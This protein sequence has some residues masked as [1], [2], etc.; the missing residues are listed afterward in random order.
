MIFTILF[1]LVSLPG[2][3]TLMFELNISISPDLFVSWSQCKSYHWSN[4]WSYFTKRNHIQLG[5]NLFR[6]CSKGQD[7]FQDRPWP[8]DLSICKFSKSSS[9]ALT[10]YLGRAKL[11]KIMLIIKTNIWWSAGHGSRPGKQFFH[12][13]TK[14][15]AKIHIA[16]KKRVNLPPKRPI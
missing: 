8:F 11:F 7:Q 10:W 12:N 9:I 4:P 13:T 5:M 16:L 3:F 1:S 14:F 15:L 6:R 2:S